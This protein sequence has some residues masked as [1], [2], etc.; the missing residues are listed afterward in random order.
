[1][2]ETTFALSLTQFA[3]SLSFPERIQHRAARNGV[4]EA[5]RM[6]S[7][8]LDACFY[9]IK[10]L[11]AEEIYYISDAIAAEG[12]I[13]IVPPGGG[14]MLTICD[15]IDEYKLRGGRGVRAMA[16]AGV[17]G[18]AVG[19]AAFARN[20]ADALGEPVAAVVSGYGLGDIVFETMGGSLLFGWLGNLRNECETIDDVVGRPHL[21]AYDDRHA[22]AM[23]PHRTC[24]DAD[25]VESLL[26]DEELSFHF[27]AGHSKGN[28][29]LS[30]ALYGL[31]AENPARLRAIASGA[32]IVTF[33]ARI[34]MPPD[35]RVVTD[36]M[37]ALDWYGEMNSRPLIDSDVSVPFAGHSTN[38]DLL[39]AIDVRSTIS[40]ILAASL[41]ALIEDGGSAP[42]LENVAPP[43]AALPEL[44]AAQAP[45]EVVAEAVPDVEDEVEP[46]A[47]A[48]VEVEVEVEADVA[49]E[50]TVVAEAEAAPEAAPQPLA[51]APAPEDLPP[52]PPARPAKTPVARRSP[53]RT[54]KGSSRR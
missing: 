48:A 26:A 4:L 7:A 35:F 5:W 49:H 11:T 31:K 37:G 19:A 12:L 36:V 16:V 9:D 27:L 23:K 34:T 6:R 51:A 8:G 24:L 21:G 46:V 1:M 25:T 42:A 2:F 54:G 22:V 45:V 52:E 15:S 17:G 41:P 28:V 38:T 20:V 40:E 10:V 47:E 30:Q 43:A 32:R 50:S 18:S 33:G 3:R 29:V 14:E 44:V 53:P 39:G 13:M